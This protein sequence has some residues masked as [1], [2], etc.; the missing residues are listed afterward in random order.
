[1]TIIK[2]FKIASHLMSLRKA[3]D[4]DYKMA[5]TNG[6]TKPLRVVFATECKELHSVAKC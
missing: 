5:R 1:M 4:L 6:H 2:L 3:V